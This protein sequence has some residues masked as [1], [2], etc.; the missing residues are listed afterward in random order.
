MPDELQ[1]VSPEES[2]PRSSSTLIVGAVGIVLLVVIVILLEVL[3][4]DTAEM[5]YQRKV[6]AEQPQEL[7]LLQAEQRE[8]LNSYHWVDRENGVVAITIER[9][10]EIVVQESGVA[11]AAA[12]SEAR[13]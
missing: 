11:G 12:S 9:A 5:E 13:P 10:M 3:F 6:V 7:R 4:Y 8:K 2:D 1:M